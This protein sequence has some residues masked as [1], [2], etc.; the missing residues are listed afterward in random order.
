MTRAV[1]LVV[2]L[3]TLSSCRQER[4]SIVGS[5]HFEGIRHTDGKQLLPVTA[6]DTLQLKESTFSYFLMAKDSL[7]ASGTWK[8]SGD[9]LTFFYTYPQDTTRHYTISAA[10]GE[11]LTF[12]EGPAVFSFTRD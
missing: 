8:R 1:L 9:S 4:A 2:T 7:F 3:F 5:Y 12:S 11:N 10:D 6:A